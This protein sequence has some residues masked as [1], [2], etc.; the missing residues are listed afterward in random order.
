MTPYEYGYFSKSAT[1]TASGVPLRDTTLGGSTA[2]ADPAENLEPVLAK[3]R[4]APVSGV[5]PNSVLKKQ[6]AA[7]TAMPMPSTPTTR[8]ASAA[9]RPTGSPSLT[10]AASSPPAGGIQPNLALRSQAMQ[11]NA[12]RSVSAGPFG[13]LG[14]SGGASRVRGLQQ[15]A[16]QSQPA[17]TPP[18]AFSQLP[19]DQKW[20]QVR[21]NMAN[22]KAQLAQTRALRSQQMQLAQQNAAQQYPAPVSTNSAAQGAA[23]IAAGP[24]G[25]AGGFGSRV[26]QSARPMA[27]AAPGAAPQ[28]PLQLSMGSRPAP[29]APASVVAR[30]ATPTAPGDPTDLVS[31]ARQVLQ[32][33]WNNIQ[34]RLT[35]AGQMGQSQGS[36]AIQQALA[37]LGGQTPGQGNSSWLSPQNLPVL[38][39]M[40]GLDRLVNPAI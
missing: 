10:S 39:K 36:S 28:Q 9:S 15:L 16:Q 20:M 3:H 33:S 31:S 21:Q 22:Q 2:K 7:R 37:G 23:S 40:F 18:T 29:P 27:P 26:V 1:Q 4:H 35:Q 24:P 17:A 6:A 12:S 34:P 32:N 30:Q 38:L 19:E 11:N 8:G 25:A 14:G 5:L 13:S